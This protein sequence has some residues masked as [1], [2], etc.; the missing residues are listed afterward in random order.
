MYADTRSLPIYRREVVR[1]R[2]LRIFAGCSVL[3]VL[4]ALGA[5]ARIPLPFTPV[6]FTMQVFFL[7]FGAMAL[8]RRS[9]GSQAAY[10]GAGALGLPIFAGFAGGV[11]VLTGVTAGYLAGFVLCAF[12]IG[13]FISKNKPSVKKDAAVIALGMM[14]Y[15]IPGVL[16]LS[17]VTG[18]GL[19]SAF[20]AGFLP[21][22]AGDVMKAAAAYAI[23]RKTLPR[24]KQL[25]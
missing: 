1:S 23:Y 11:S 19:K 5:L 22:I 2:S 3:T 12:V 25:F 6:P 17:A 14:A 13:S 16:W 21:F 4:M 18:I 20:A 8:G 15:Y 7:F 24:L 10:V 9:A